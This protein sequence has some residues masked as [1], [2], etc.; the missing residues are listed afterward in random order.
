VCRS[1]R[2]G[3]S[4]SAEAAQWLLSGAQ[5]VAGSRG[6]FDWAG[7][8]V[9]RLAVRRERLEAARVRRE[10]DRAAQASA[11]PSEP[12]ETAQEAAE[13]EQMELP[14]PWPPRSRRRR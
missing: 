7:P 9:T 8:R 4:K 13:S 2:R 14:I 3:L 1:A 10:A 6:R 12:P 11:D 5:V